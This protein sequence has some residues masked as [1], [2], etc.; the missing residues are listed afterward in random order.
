MRRKKDKRKQERE[1]KKLYPVIIN[2]LFNSFIIIYNENSW[3]APSPSTRQE[4]ERK[5]REEELRR[6]RALKR[7]EIETK[8]AQI[9]SISGMNWF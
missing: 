7:Q 6:L 2:I 3:R 5:R 1:A 4:D 8:L 9:Q